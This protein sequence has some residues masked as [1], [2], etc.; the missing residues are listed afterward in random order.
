MGIK[1]ANHVAI[2]VTDL[3]K[4]HEFYGDLMGLRE[5]ER[6]PEV[7]AGGPGAWYQIDGFQLHLFV[8]P[9]PG[10]TSTRHVGV[11]VDD[12]DAL[13]EKIK[14]KGIPLEDAFSF[15]EFKRRKFTRDPSGNLVEL[16]SRK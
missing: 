8:G 4:A 12:L 1:A 11:E 16:M 10:A 6:P 13:A 14:M 7:V 5:I 3:Q 15:G 2:I 9:D